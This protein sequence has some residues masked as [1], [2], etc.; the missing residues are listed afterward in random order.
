MSPL[1]RLD[2]ALEDIIRQVTLRIVVART[3]E[4]EQVS[5]IANEVCDRYKIGQSV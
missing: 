3:S 1:A 2:R 5:E 4:F